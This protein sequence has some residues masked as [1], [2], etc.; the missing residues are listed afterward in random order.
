MG[1]SPYTWNWS[2]GDTTSSINIHPAATT[3]YTVTITDQCHMSNVD[4]IHVIVSKPVIHTTGDTICEGDLATVSASSVGATTYEWNTGDLTESI[5]VS[6]S[7][8]S[9]YSVIVTD[10]IGCKDTAEAIVIVHP[11]PIPYITND[12][13]IC[14]NDTIELSAGGGV[15]YNWNTGDTLPEIIVSPEFSMQYSVT[16]TDSEN[17][18]KDASVWL[19]VIQLPETKIYTDND[20]ICRGSTATLHATGATEYQWSTGETSSSILVNPPQETIYW[21]TGAN[22]TNNVYCHHT[23]TFRL[24][25]IRCNRFYV[26][27]AFNPNGDG[28]ND[29]FGPEGNFDGIERFEIFIF[30]RTGRVIFHSLDPFK[31]WDG[32]MPDGQLAPETVYAYRMYIKEAYAE[33]Y[34]MVGTVTLIR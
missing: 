16:V 18:S 12:T 29:D 20:T 10:T 9:V 21:V 22:T 28:H 1:V 3:T 11:L 25:V 15:A 27:N 26:P 34:Q 8:T 32:T 7:N 23:D 13:T 4:S 24:M 17:C 5:L 6:P 30:D 14:R 2:T 31:R 33:E 19:E